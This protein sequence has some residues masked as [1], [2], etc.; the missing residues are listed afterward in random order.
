MNSLAFGALMH[1]I[2]KCKIDKKVLYK[3]SGMS[4]S[5]KKLFQM[6]PF[7]GVELLSGMKE[8]NKE[9]MRIIYHHHVR[10]ENH[11]YPEN[12]LFDQVSILPRIVAIVDLY[13]NLINKRD[14]ETSLTPHKALANM[15]KS[16]SRFLDKNVLS[17]FIRMMGVYP[18]GS[19]SELDTGEVALVVSIGEDPLLPDVIVYD[20]NIPKNEAMILRLG[21]DIESRIERIISRKDLTQEQIKYLSPKTKIGYYA[22]S[23]GQS[24]DGSAKK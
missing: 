3:K 4:K 14:Y 17:H 13:D 9:V 7:Y 1:D 10:N 8:V 20:P 21:R 16:A 18:P 23:N 11:G 24:V 2:G 6:H 5:E 12:V 15:Y 19:I 22:D